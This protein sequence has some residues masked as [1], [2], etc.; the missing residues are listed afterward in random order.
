M[1]ILQSVKKLGNRKRSERKAASDAKNELKKKFELQV[2]ADVA[3][4]DVDESIVTEYLDQFGEPETVW[5]QAVQGEVARVHALDVQAQREE[6]YKAKSGLVAEIRE[7][8]ARSKPQ[9]NHAS[10]AGPLAIKAEK[11]E[12]KIRDNPSKATPSDYKNWRTA[13]REVEDD[14]DRIE[15]INK[16]VRLLDRQLAALV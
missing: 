7:L 2:I 10:L 13:L 12:R 3:G 15:Q 5:K 1:Q 11:L 4:E 8:T 6:I 16:E 9:D 14:H